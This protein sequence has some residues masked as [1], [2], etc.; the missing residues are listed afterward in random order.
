MNND[1]SCILNSKHYY[2]GKIYFDFNNKK[3]ILIEDFYDIIKINGIHSFSIINKLLNSG[4]L[5]KYNRIISEIL[6]NP[7]LLYGHVITNVVHIEKYNMDIRVYVDLYIHNEYICNSKYKIRKLGEIHNIMSCLYPDICNIFNIIEE[8]S[9]RKSKTNDSKYIYLHKSIENWF[10]SEAN[11]EQQL[12]KIQYFDYQKESIQWIIDKENCDNSHDFLWFC[13]S[14]EPLLYYIPSI[15]VFLSNLPEQWNNNSRGGIIADET[16]LGKTIEMLSVIAMNPPSIDYLSKSYND[17]PNIKATLVICPVNIITQWHDEV[18]KVIKNDYKIYICKKAIDKKLTTDKLAEYDIVLI[19]FSIVSKLKQ[20]SVFFNVNFYRMVWDECHSGHSGTVTLYNLK[21]FRSNIKWGLTG[22]PTQKYIVSIF[23]ILGLKPFLGEQYIYYKSQQ[24]IY[25]NF[26]IRHTSNY[27]KSF[28][29]PDKIEV[30]IDI[31]MTPNEKEFYDKLFHIVRSKLKNLSFYHHRLKAETLLNHLFKYCS[32]GHYNVSINSNPQK[33]YKFIEDDRAPN[34][35][36]CSIC[37]DIFDKP[38]ITPCNHWFCLECIINTLN[39]GRNKCP[40]CRAPLMLKNMQV[41][42][43]EESSLDDILEDSILVKSKLDWLISDISNQIQIDSTT[44]FIIFSKENRTLLYLQSLLKENSIENEIIHGSIAR[45]KRDKAIQKFNNDINTKVFLL[46]LKSSAVGLNLTKASHM[47][48]LEPSVNISRTHQAIAR[49]YRLG[50]EKKVTI[51]KL[52]YKD[53][54]ETKIR[55][56]IDNKLV[57]N[58][59]LNEEQFK[60]IMQ[61]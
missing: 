15:S 45:D 14:S 60:H 30:N 42:K 23:D 55:E 41:T 10:E 5:P 53:S 46:S 61:L 39:I 54:V 28:K 18:N 2:L 11:I 33:E 21:K 47:Y 12:F 38:S 34:D 56:F 51:K 24:Y 50:Q 8:I 32:G 16:G 48:I 6:R 58:D 19:P 52:Y 36:E 43:Y 25:S 20:D 7:L 59:K 37:L 31:D 40:L 35:N 9:T 27:I 49:I 26:I 29:L 44:K 3:S 22:T 17:L 57:I 1:I 4:H 13:I